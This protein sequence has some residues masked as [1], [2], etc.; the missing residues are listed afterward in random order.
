MRHGECTS[1]TSDRFINRFQSLRVRFFPSKKK[2]E[3]FSGPWLTRVA[4][5]LVLSRA[6]SDQPAWSMA[7][8]TAE[9]VALRHLLF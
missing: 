3:M 4:V 6:A 9:A 1:A 7:R 8:Q 5:A 2:R